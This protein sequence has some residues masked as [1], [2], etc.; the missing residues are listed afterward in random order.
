MTSR[1][2][3]M[4]QRFSA[5]ARR[6]SV[7]AVHFTMASEAA[8]RLTNDAAASKSPSHARDSNGRHGRL[9]L[10]NNSRNR[11]R[12][13]PTAPEPDPKCSVCDK[14]PPKYKCPKCRATYCSIACCK[15]HKEGELCQPDAAL[16]AKQSADGKRSKYSAA[17]VYLSSTLPSTY[18]QAVPRAQYSDSRNSSLDQNIEDEDWKISSA[19]TEAMHSSAWLQDEL[20]DE[21]LRQILTSIV[22]ASNLVR[23]HKTTTLQEECMEQLKNASPAFQLFIDKLLVMTG[24]L[25]RPATL[26]DASSLET[27]LRESTSVKH[28][29]GPLVFKSL[30]SK[31]PPASTLPPVQA[32]ASSE[33]DK[34][35]SSDSDSEDSSSSDESS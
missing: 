10:N 15:K 27:W 9:A 35:S 28:S 5:T 4:S 7:F 30:P 34:S 3:S 16:E 25:Q 19:M 18:I 8:T 20:Q 31:R 26:G 1:R 21:S 14:G 29:E 22:N 12:K 11:K 6:A 2:E 32:D 24:N 23:R 17:A 33:N 13:A